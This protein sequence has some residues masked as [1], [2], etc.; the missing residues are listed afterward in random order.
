MF[1]SSLSGVCVDPFG[2]VYVLDHGDLIT[3][4]K[5]TQYC[6][7]RRIEKSGEEYMEHADLQDAH[8]LSAVFSSIPN[9]VIS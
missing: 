2:N 3:D 1:E 6:V 8:D 4:N 7:L 5:T 9:R